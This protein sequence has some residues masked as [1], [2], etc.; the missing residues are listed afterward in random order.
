MLPGEI[1]LYRA[2]GE[3]Y[4]HRIAYELYVTGE[5]LLLYTMTGRF[6]PKERVVAEPLIGISLL[7]Y[8]ESGLFSNQGRLDVGFLGNTLTLTGAPETIKGVW[9]A[10]QGH[11]PTPPSLPVDEEVTIVASPAPLFDDM[12]G[13]PAQVEPLPTSFNGRPR[14]TV[15]FGVACLLAVAAVAAVLLAA[16]NAGYHILHRWWPLL[17]PSQSPPRRLHQSRS[18]SWTRLSLSKKVRTAQ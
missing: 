13:P 15:V 9:Q 11:T 16:V 4:Y 6:A 2:A 5:R 3:V 18:T 7:E 10:L 8:S 17:H 14:N 12:A 1:I